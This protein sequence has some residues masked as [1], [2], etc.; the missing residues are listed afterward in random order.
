MD[1][2]KFKPVLQEK[3]ICERRQEKEQEQLRQKYHLPAKKYIEIRKEHILTSF[4]KM[5]GKTVRM[6]ALTI[7][8]VLAFI[9]MTAIIYPESRAVLLVIYQDAFNQLEKFFPV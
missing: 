1:R 3:I 4:T 8:F 7:L 2:P 6:A 9:G 5:I